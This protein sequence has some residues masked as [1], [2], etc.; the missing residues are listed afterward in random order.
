M[1]AVIASAAVVAGLVGPAHAYH[2]ISSFEVTANR[3]GAAGMYATG[4]ARFKGYTCDLC[5]TGGEGRVS[6]SVT[7]EPTELIGSGIYTPGQTYTIQV[8]LLGEHRGLESAF[9]PNTFTADVLDAAGVPVGALGLTADPIVRLASD[10]TIAIAEG[11]GNGE[12][13]W[14]FAWSAPNDSGRLAFHLA[15]LDGDGASDPIT[16]FIDP[17]N[18]DVA[19]FE[20]TLCPA[21]AACPE[22][23]PEPEPESPAAGCAVSAGDLPIWPIFLLLTVAVTRRRYG[24]RRSQSRPNHVVRAVAPESSADRSSSIDG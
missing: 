23:E 9:N 17:F 3:G 6:V 5:H 20:A 15:L 14:T 4:S 21:A 7:S 13:G 22:P 1:K 2:E 16:R 10:Q 18:D 8:E 12:T 24:F 11:L 19:I